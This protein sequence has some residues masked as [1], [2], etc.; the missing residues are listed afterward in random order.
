MSPSVPLF[1]RRV[2]R[3]AWLAGLLALPA[4]QLCV[5]V[6]SGDADPAPAVE[7]QPLVRV[8][9][10]HG[11]FIIELFNV[12][13]PKTV[14]NFLQYVN[15]GFY[16]GTIFHQVLAGN[17]VAAGRYQEDLE[18]RTTRP[19]VANESNNGLSNLRG[20]VALVE[21]DGDGT[22]TGTSAF[23][24]HL[25]DN[26]SR[27]FNLESG[28]R[29]LTVFGRVAAGMEVVAAIGSVSTTSRRAQDD[30]T[31]S[32]L[33]IDAV[34][35]IRARV[36]HDLSVSENHAPIA[37]AGPDQIVDVGA[38]VV[39]DAAGSS[40][41]DGDAISLTWRLTSGPPVA[42]SNPSVIRPSFSAAAVATLTFE[43]TATDSEGATS[44]DTVTVTVKSLENR[45]PTANAGHDQVVTP[46]T[47][48][49]LDATDSRDPDGQELT[50][51]WV[52]TGGTTVALSD[53]TASRP[54]FSAPN[55][56]GGITFELTVTDPFGGLATDTVVVTVNLPPTADAGQDRLVAEKVVVALRG[57]GSDGDTSGALQFAWTQTAG[58]AVTLSNP[59]IAQPTFTVPEGALPLSFRLTVT[60]AAGAAS[61]DEVTL[62]PVTEPRV[63]L[64]TTRGDVVFDLFE[65]EAPINAVNF[66]QY[67]EDGFYD[68]TI[69][70]RVVNEPDPFV[71]QGGGFEPGLVKRTAG[72]RAAVRNEFSPDRSNLRGTVAMAKLANDPDSATSQFFVNLADNSENLDHQNGG[73]TVFATVIEGMDVVD[74]IAAVANSTRQAPDGSSMENVP[75]VDIIVNS[76]RLE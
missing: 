22:G 55:V 7:P 36:T 14:A 60:D 4:G 20:R 48:V 50:F 61:S 35:I 76:A 28:R 73:F 33:P 11:V 59:G 53:P 56:S 47:T 26:T 68:G 37:D 69:I 54:T 18:P 62:T 10:T 2:W 43:L 15:D 8:E 34:K 3:W 63:R 30:Q 75:D 17:T 44:T 5:P 6:D 19:A 49:T 42:L 70:H 65:D 27:D 38:V 52:Q 1:A 24:I 40:D 25:R 32:N 74:A 51:R 46:G 64:A 39:L 31:L 67:V 13:A 16:D 71:I 41:P 66:L 23:L 57:A 21:P 45:P 29:G 12:Q 72:L 9:T 58:P